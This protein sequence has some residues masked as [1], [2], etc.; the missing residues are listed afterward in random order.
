MSLS[1]SRLVRCP[2]FPYSRS[3]TI[4]EY[5]ERMKWTGGGHFQL[6]KPAMMVIDAPRDVST[7]DDWWG[8]A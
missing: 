2:L 3:L 6:I 8:A 7:S 1:G 4:R 5:C